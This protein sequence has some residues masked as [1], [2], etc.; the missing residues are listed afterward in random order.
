MAL[1]VW[2]AEEIAGVLQGML[3]ARSDWAEP[4]QAVAQALGCKL[5]PPRMVPV[6]HITKAIDTYTR[7]LDNVTG[8]WYNVDK[9]ATGHD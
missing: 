1:Q 5:E 4:L 3:M 6:V 2:F 7:M 9:H 8:E